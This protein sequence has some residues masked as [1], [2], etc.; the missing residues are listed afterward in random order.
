MGSLLLLKSPRNRRANRLFR[1]HHSPSPP[2]RATAF[3]SYYLSSEAGDLVACL[4]LL[5]R[6]PAR[7]GRRPDRR[8]HTR[9]NG[10]V[11]SRLLTPLCAGILAA[12][13]ALAAPAIFP[14]RDVRAGQKGVG[15]TVFSGSRVE[16]F[17][18]EILGVLENVGPRQ[19]I[20]LARLRG[21]PLAD[22]GVMQG[23]SGSPVYIDGKLAGAVAMGFPGAK[24]AIAGLRPIEEMLA[25]E[26]SAPA[27]A[28]RAAI[29]RL[30]AD[31][32]GARLEELTTPLAFSGFTTATL[33]RFSEQLRGLGMDPRQG[34]TGGGRIPDAL[35]D[36]ARLEPGSMI[37]VQLLSGDMSVSA[38]GTVTAIDGD[39]VYAF[40][41]RFLSAGATELPFARS[42]VL[43]LLP[44]I[45]SSFKI[46]RATEW[47]GTISQDRGAAISGVTGRRAAMAPFEIRAGGNAYRM[48]MVQDRVI[49]PLLA[50]MALASALDA[51]GRAVG[52]ATY[53]VKTRIHFAG[54]A[55]LDL[56]NAYTGDISVSALASLG[57][58]TPLSYALASG[59][60]ALKLRDVA[61]EV[62]LLDRRSVMQVAGVV[63]PRS[64]RPG[65]TIEITVL[66]SGEN[67][68]EM[69]RKA[70]F[71]IPVGTPAGTLNLTA[72]DA[73]ST[74]VLEYQATIG[75]Q[76]RSP[77]QV[78]AVLG[79]LRSNTSAYLRVWRAG[80]AYTVE[81]RDLPD[82]PPSAALIFARAQPPGA[83]ASTRGAK[84]AEIEIAG[85]A[86]VVTGSRSIQIEVRE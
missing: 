21:G 12:S 63:A 71:R 51:A 83:P 61:L 74:N 28:N 76:F 72:A 75:M 32:S 84:L 68:A 15:K 38:D 58:A 43:A 9:Y 8:P 59:F 49:T 7:N 29:P 55:T 16:E 81:G 6:I 40:G 30:R 64:A 1:V 31:V 69:A 42:E 77:E 45:S 2:R 25:V 48:R 57:V 80:S 66:L 20:I 44:N 14:L 22:T 24:D 79:G 50:Q 11:S 53:S 27:G 17:Q 4:G 78:L 54:G 47:M 37:S 10:V 3:L 73:P 34:V 85:G 82:P 86:G 41:H 18:V 23:M 26:P 46:S 65:E 35:G 39:K 13:A 67:G 52:P 56:N 36:P 5:G 60:D 70:N 62:S 33:D 19:S